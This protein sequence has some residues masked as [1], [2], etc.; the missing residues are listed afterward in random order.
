MTKN[1]RTNNTQGFTIIELLVVIVVIG[2]LAAITTVGFN[3]VRV[4]AIEA[5]LRADLSNASKKADLYQAEYGN[6]PESLADIGYEPHEDSED[7]ESMYW[8]ASK[9]S[10]NNVFFY[11]MV[12][13][14]QSQGLCGSING[15]GTCIP[16]YC[17]N[18]YSPSTEITLSISSLSRTP[19]EGQCWISQS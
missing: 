14:N 16:S 12:N 5:S 4:R 8:G 13:F 2:I 1:R 3:G 10:D 19:Q 17:V 7:E 6:Y 11:Q 9:G 15:V 18:A